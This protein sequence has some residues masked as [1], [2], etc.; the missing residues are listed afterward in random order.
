MD[1]A[2]S[3]FDLGVGTRPRNE[4]KVETGIQLQAVQVFTC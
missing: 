3:E 1:T 4:E 2:A